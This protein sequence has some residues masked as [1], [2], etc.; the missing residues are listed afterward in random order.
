MS[1][2]QL[3]E[4]KL[5]ENGRVFY[6]RCA[7]RKIRIK[8]VELLTGYTKPKENVIYIS[9]EKTAA[10]AI[11]RQRGNFSGSL[12]IFLISASPSENKVLQD[13]A[14]KNDLSILLSEKSEIELSLCAAQ[15]LSYYLDAEDF[16][17]RCIPPGICWKY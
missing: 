1:I 7:G 13:Q 2:F 8:S 12:G 6:K 10:S 4:S 11:Q 3:L 15:A 9:N 14:E 16:L 17:I 5:N